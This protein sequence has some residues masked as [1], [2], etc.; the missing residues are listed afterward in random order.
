LDFRTKAFNLIFS[1]ISIL[2][3]I[4]KTLS[5]KDFIQVHKSFIVKNNAIDLIEGN[6]INI[7]GNKIPIGRNYKSNLFK[8]IINKK[9]LTK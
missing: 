7:K 9:Y 4:L 5:E 6:T 2:Y 8:S 3:I 1:E